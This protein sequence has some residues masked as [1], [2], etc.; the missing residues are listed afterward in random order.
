MPVSALGIDYEVIGSVI[1]VRASHLAVPAG[2]HVIPRVQLLAPAVEHDCTELHNT[3]E[4]LCTQGIVYQVTIWSKGVG[5]LQATAV[6]LEGKAHRIHFLA[7][8][9]DSLTVP[10]E[11]G[12]H[13]HLVTPFLDKGILQVLVVAMQQHLV[14]ALRRSGIQIHHPVVMG[15]PPCIILRIGTEQSLQRSVLRFLQVH[16]IRIPAI[17]GNPLRIRIC[18]LGYY[19]RHLSHNTHRQQEQQK[20]TMDIFHVD[21][22]YIGLYICNMMMCKYTKIIL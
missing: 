6:Y 21:K 3:L 14:T 10:G 11:C 1:H 22:L 15:A 17:Q 4:L 5:E 7:G 20:K 12:A 16:V 13:P 18:D 9:D 19:R 2:I 8:I